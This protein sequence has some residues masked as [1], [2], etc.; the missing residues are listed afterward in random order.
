MGGIRWNLDK[1][2]NGFV[3]AASGNTVANG[4]P[5]MHSLTPLLGM[6]QNQGRK[7][8]L[9]TD[10]RLSGASGKI[11]SAIHVTPE[12]A[13]GGALARLRDGDLIHLDGDA[14]KLD[15]IIDAATWDSRTS[16][17]DTTPIVH[18]LG[19]S[20]FAGNRAVVTPAD[21]GALSIS[22]GLSQHG[23]SESLYMDAEYD[24]GKGAGTAPHESKDA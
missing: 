9:L 10:G 24:L 4:M 3:E 13:V 18:D 23:A 1:W 15:V 11:L 19:R 2:A 22:C 16:D 7:V 14:G 17:C 21:Q 20:L 6:L 12:A 8:A 5:E